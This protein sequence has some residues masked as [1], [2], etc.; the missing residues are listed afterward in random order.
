MKKCIAFVMAFICVLSLFGCASDEPKRD[1]TIDELK[2]IAEKGENISWSDFEPYSYYSRAGSG[3][4]YTSYLI[5]DEYML[6]IVGWPN[7][8]IQSIT[9]STVV[10]ANG[11]TD[12]YLEIDIRTESID[13]FLNG[14]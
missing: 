3:I 2:V 1:L 7:A 10:L 13:D 9:L 4:I 8:Y 6:T 14:K 11:S 5:G 12:E